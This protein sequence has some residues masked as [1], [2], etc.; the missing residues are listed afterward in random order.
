MGSEP[1]G[2]DRENGGHKGYCFLAVLTCVLSGANWGP[3]APPFALRQE[4]PE[5]NFQFVHRG[6]VAAVKRF[7]PGV[8]ERQ[9]M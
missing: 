1:L 4:T 5:R 3:F 6:A 8:Q 2:S 9:V 7:H